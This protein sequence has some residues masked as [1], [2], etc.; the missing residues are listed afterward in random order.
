MKT[1]FILIITCFAITTNHIDKT[2][3]EDSQKCS[4]ELTVKQNRNF[5]SAYDENGVTFSLELMNTSTNNVTYSLSTE[6]V[7]NPCGNNTNKRS[8][9]NNIDLDVAFQ[10]NNYNL[11]S[12]NNNSPKNEI[13]LHGGETYK[14]EVTLKVPKN[15]P[16]YNWGCVEVIAKSKDCESSL[17]KTILS[18]YNPDP[19]DK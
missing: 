5:K 6:K 12:R 8:S 10:L 19:T 17:V 15:T 9:T 7:K 4:A 13:T 1:I 16:F 11:S 3:I 2:I 18:V 14:F